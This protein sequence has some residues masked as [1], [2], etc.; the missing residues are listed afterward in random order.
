MTDLAVDILGVPIAQV[1]LVDAGR[2][3]I[4]ASTGLEITETERDVAFCS[5]VIL[6]DEVL[7]VPDTAQDPRFRD[8]PFVTGPPHIRFYAGA[9]LRSRDGFRVGGL[10]VA[11]GRPRDDFGPEQIDRL[12]SLAEV[13]SDLLHLR[14]W[15]TTAAGELAE[16]Q[17]I[18]RRLRNSERRTRL[19]IHE[20]GEG[21]V[22]IDGESRVQ[23]WNRRAEQIFGW[24]RDEIIGRPLTETIIPPRLRDAHLAG[25]AR[26]METGEGAVLFRPVEVTALHRDGHEFPVE[27][28]V[29]PVQV[30]EESTFHA[31]VRDITERKRAEEAITRAKEAAEAADRAKSEFLSRMSHELR[32]PLNAILG[33]SQLLEMDDLSEEQLDSL[34]EIRKGGRHLLSLINEVLDIARIESGRLSLSI[35]PVYLQ[36]VVSQAVGLMRSLAAG[37]NV[38]IETDESSLRRFVS[39]DHQRLNQVLL[40][41]FSN[42]IKYNERGGKVVIACREADGLVHLDV[43]DTGKGIDPSRMDRLFTPFDRLGAEQTL[44]E[45]SGLGLALS[46]TLI[47]A[48]GGEITASRGDDGGMT[49]TVVLEAA[50]SQLSDLEVDSVESQ[51][52]P[53]VKLSARYTILYIEDNL[54]N[55]KLIEQTLGKDADVQLLTAIQGG[56]GVQLA[57]EHRPDLIL[58]DLHLPD[59]PGAAVLRQLTEDRRTS[60]IPVVIVSADATHRQVERLLAAGARAYV[61][62]PLD[63]A[64]LRAV[65]ERVLGGEVL[66]TGDEGNSDVP[67]SP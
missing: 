43:T 50:S 26:F 18:E 48:M 6:S 17:T 5:H 9:P 66:A 8:G 7:V 12:R 39:G 27:I 67:T 55:L 24:G 37:A 57:R 56:M 60:E 25:I 14:R 41:L 47:E 22:S 33:F 10:C 38:S 58:L 36:D 42:A 13:T 54:S 40:N 11:D 35:E 44:V 21:F 52:I 16:R 45:G 30:G 15:Q 28:N 2:Q 32:T 64:E 51:E 59:I 20:S 49:F 46:R 29:W 1:S 61:T 3:W 53:I 19:I 34:G 65:V 63:L 4:K 23:E 31:F 62:K